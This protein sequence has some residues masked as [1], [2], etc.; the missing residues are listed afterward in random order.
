MVALAPMLTLAGK[1]EFTVIVTALEVT[2]DPVKQGDAV[3]VITA[4]TTSLLAKVVVENVA[5]VSPGTIT[6]FTFH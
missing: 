4:V 5:A 2:G 1:K 3:D 6:P